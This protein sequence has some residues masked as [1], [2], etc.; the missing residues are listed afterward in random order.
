MR[1]AEFCPKNKNFSR[2]PSLRYRIQ[3]VIGIHNVGYKEFYSR[4]IQQLKMHKNNVLETWLDEKD[5]SK[6]LNKK[7]REL[8]KNKRK[9]VHKR[10]A[11]TL[12]ELLLE[13]QIDP[14]AGTYCTG[15]GVTGVHT[16]K[17]KLKPRAWCSCG[18]KKHKNKN[19]K[20][21]LLGNGLVT[22]VDS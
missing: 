19:S 2:T 21:C 22:I 20:H 18:G 4:V 6:A 12:A 17:A 13:R 5:T 7:N 11:K 10:N 1:N 15:I 14:K 8:G 16:E 9:R 3:N